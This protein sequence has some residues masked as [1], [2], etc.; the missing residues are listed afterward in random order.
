MKKFTTA[1]LVAAAVSSA[2]CKKDL[3]GN[4]PVTTETRTVQY[5]TGIDLQMNGHVYYTSSPERKIEI[6]A[7]ESIRSILETVIIENRLV[8]RYQNG[9][10]YDADE[11]IRINVSAPDVNAFLLNTSGSIYSMNDLQVATLMLRSHGSGNI[12]L[13]KINT[14]NIDAESTQS[15]R[16]TAAGGTTI[17]SK[18]KTDGSGTINLSAVNARTV[19]AR[20]IGSGDI[21]TKASENLDVT[22]QGSGSVYF[23]GYPVISTHISGSGRLVRL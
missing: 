14:T 15:G 20:I 22:I 6:T 2:S 23:S 5:F 7:K 21:Q 11:S 13:Q 16:I 8:I 18:L 10:T 17:S 1:I 3:I 12:S 9:K 19:Q 4:G